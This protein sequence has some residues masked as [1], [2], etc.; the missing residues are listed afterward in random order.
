[1]NKV[2]LVSL[3]ALSFVTA[4]ARSETPDIML[5]VNWPE[6][7]ENLDPVWE[8]LPSVPKHGPM[9]GN[10]MLGTYLIQDE[11][12]GEIRFEMSRSDLCDVR[13]GFNRRKTNGYFKLALNGERPTGTCRLDLWNAQLTADL[14]VS[15][16]S[17]SLRAFADANSDVIVFVFEQTGVN[18]T[19]D[20]VPDN[21]GWA[22]TVPKIP[23][24]YVPYPEPVLLEYQ[25]CQ[26]SVQD[27]PT[28]QKYWTQHEPA[29]S[30]HATAWR[31]LHAKGKTYVFASTT[32][33][34]RTS[35]AKQQAV[36]N[37]NQAISKGFPE[38]EAE[39]Q[40]WWQEFYQQSFVT[41]PQK[42][43]WFHWMQIYKIG[44]MTRPDAP[45]II[46]L[47][48]P[49]FDRDLIWNGIWFNWNTQKQY[50]NVFTSNHPE[51]A[52]SLLNSLWNQRENLYDAESDGYGV[53][54][55]GCGAHNLARQN[56]RDA[57]CLTW[58]L[59][60]G[61][62]RYQCTM[63]AEQLLNKVYPMLKGSY[64]YMKH[65]YL[66][67]G[68]DG[69]LH[70]KPGASPE[71]HFKV[72]GVKIRDFEDITF[73]IA[74]MRWA[75]NTI[76]KI[77]ERYG[78]D[79]ADAIECRSIL[80]RLTPYCVD[81]EQG[82]MIGK[83]TLLGHA[84]RHDSHE[85][86]I[87]PY[88]E[89]TPD[90]PEQV[91]VIQK[92]LA[93]HKNIGFQDQGMAD[94]TWGIM[95][96]MFG[97]GNDALWSI[98]HE[99]GYVNH[100]DVSPYTTRLAVYKTAYVEEGPFLGDRVIQEM[101]LQSWGDDII[102]VFPAVPDDPDWDDL[103][104]HNFRAKGAFLVTA[105]RADRKT[106]FIKIES[107][108]GEVCKVKF[109]LDGPI[110]IAGNADCTITDLGN[111]IIQINNLKKGQWCVLYTGPLPDLRIVAKNL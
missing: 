100:P 27:M 58:L 109:D 101:L 74:N 57:A 53:P 102:R 29:A 32:F 97:D 68:E 48:G 83:D 104:F 21:R 67:E 94:A 92:T 84:H 108:E 98:T 61:W 50:S 80:D 72:D 99:T 44:C 25:K 34:Y 41:L 18:L 42:F 76:I 28:D 66:V 17:L 103:A 51:L 5:D 26:V 31:I 95:R 3:V 65:H 39:H 69:L 15:D 78:V 16:G 14:Q 59:S 73:Q 77:N 89:Y 35:T 55:G 82:F 49:W 64:N 105:K 40:A 86:Q 13:A 106:S 1:M 52:D 46:D 71:Y 87:F 6:F 96:A 12:T 56:W 8:E 24:G 60:L 85:L 30:Q 4:M 54:W 45:V 62:E 23:D 22:G 19:W 75:C 7:M 47:I 20:W 10:G 107:L 91:D 36:D 63:D 111:G 33:A 11:E 38:L 79:E 88:Y 110:Q 93:H 81:P 90:N 37:I 9:I 70:F 2:V 43:E